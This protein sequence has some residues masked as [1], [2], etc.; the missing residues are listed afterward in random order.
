MTGPILQGGKRDSIT[1][2][3]AGTSVTPKFTVTNFTA[4]YDFDCNTAT[5]G[6]TSD[7]LGTLIRDLIARGIL[8]GTVAA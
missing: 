2:D 3:T 1:T 7:A 8:D 4:D 6:V 5:L